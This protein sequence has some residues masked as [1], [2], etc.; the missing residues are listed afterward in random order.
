M[1]RLAAAFLLAWLPAPAAQAAGCFDVS[2]GEPARLE[3]EL[4][5]R[6]F[7]GPPN[8]EDVQKGDS[9][10]PGYVLTLPQ[11][12]CLTGDAD[13]TDPSYLFDEVQLVETEATAKAM[14]E[15]R[16]RTVSVGLVNP[17]PAMTGHHHRPLVAWVSAIAPAGDP[18]ENQGTAATTVEAFYLALGA[19]DG[20]TAAAFV[21]P[22]K[23]AKGPFSAAELTRF[24]GG[25]R[26]PLQLVGVEQLANGEFL[27]SYR[28]A[29][30]SKV[31]DGR[32]LVRTENRD[33]RF[34]IR[35]IKALDGC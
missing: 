10:E 28:F 22:E 25:L 9:P 34:F 12:I 19:G 15:L 11:P 26:E 20:A 6:I 18:T 16:N 2:A 23:T 5:F 17:M 13:F 8:F 35:S 29:S 4:S 3:G 14:R 31:C 30:S 7:A 33:G 32:A 1:K 24:Y 27:A 21:I